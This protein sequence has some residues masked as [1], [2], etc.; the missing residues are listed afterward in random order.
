MRILAIRGRNLASLSG[1]FAIDFTA[2]PLA[3]AG[4][5]AI[6]GPTGAGK[7]TLLDALCLALYDRT[8]RVARVG[9]R[10]TVLPDVAGETIG[11][12]DT[13][14]LLRRGAAEGHAEV[15]FVGGDG[16]AYRA[17]WS[18]RRARGKAGGK[19]Q[20]TQMSLARLPGDEPVGGGLKTEVQAAI[21]ERV[22]LTFEQFTRAVLL[23]QNEFFAFLKAGDDERAALLQAL[24]GTGRF[25]A[26][27]RR[28]F[29]RNKA[30]QEALRQLREQAAQH[31]PLDA[32]TRAQCERQRRQQQDAVKALDERLRQYEAQLR[33]HADAA[34]LARLEQQAIDR[35]RDAVAAHDAA[36]PRR[37]RL[38]D[39]HAAQPARALVAEIDRLAAQ[40]EAQRQELARA[41]EALAAAARAAQDAQAE[42]QRAAAA[43]EA[44]RHAEAAM[45]PRLAQARELDAVIAALSPDR[46]RAA[47]AHRQAG[48]ALEETRRDQARLR[49]ERESAGSALAAAEDWLVRHA[50]LEALG[51]QWPRWDALFAQADD[52][53]GRHAAATQEAARLAALLARAQQDQTDAQG[54][55]ATAAA[56]LQDAQQQY[57][58]A[59]QA[60]A[61]HDRDAIAARA[62]ELQRQRD[63]LQQAAARWR[64]RLAAEARMAELVQQRDTLQAQW[65]Q[66]RQGIDAARAA[67]PAAEQAAAQAERSWQRALAACQQGVE[68]LRETLEPGEP[69]PVCGASEHPY[70][71]DDS[72]LGAALQATLGALEDEYRRCQQALARID[73]DERSAAALARSHGDALA[74]LDT[75]LAAA[76]Q[77]CD[78]AQREWQADAV[79]AQA[80]AVDA[81]ERADWIARQLA[82]ADAQQ[83]SAAEL[84]THLRALDRQVQAARLRLDAGQAEQTA[85]QGALQRAQALAAELALRHGTAN[86]SAAATA[87]QRD[88]ALR[89]LDEGALR[90]AAGAGWRS[91]WHDDPAGLRTRC[92]EDAGQWTRHRGERDAQRQRIVQL[93]GA[94]AA[95]TQAHERALDA[96]RK[97]AEALAFADTR[98]SGRRA[99]REA[100]F[101]GTP[102][103]GL[104]VDAIAA[105]LAQAGADA[106]ARVDEAQ[107]VS[108]A[109]SEQLARQ[110]T[111]AE[112]A[113]SQ[114]EVLD[115][116]A[117]EAAARL[118]A[119]LQGWNDRHDG[120]AA[121]A[122]LD[123]A[124]LRALLALDA[125][126]LA[127][128]EASLHALQREVDAAHGAVQTRR[129]ERER[130]LAR[131]PGQDDAATV[132]AALAAARAEL[133]GAKQA[134]AEADFTLRR[135]DERR[136]QAS[137]LV[138]RIERQQ[139]TAHTWQVLNELIGSADGKKFR[140]HAQQMTLDIL[141]GYAN[142][143]LATLSRRYRL[144]RVRQSLALLVID[145]DMA[146]EAR[147][148]HSLSGGESFL[149]SLALALGL[150]SLSSHRVRVESL[151]IDEG[152]GSL[153]GDTLRVAMD[154]LDSLQ[155]Q[156]RKVGVIS[157]V[158]EMTERIGTRIEVR[159]LSGGQS[160]VTV[161][162]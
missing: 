66:C 124:G 117:R 69:C 56:S 21:V 89:A 39:A 28:A 3:S 150:A 136:A 73:A 36:A 144:E 91:Q 141:L 57:A 132:Q 157:H 121:A 135:D 95:A 64:E 100:L 94:L 33:W 20:Q 38:A 46:E 5:F 114:S 13:R 23:A 10:D 90:H 87:A 30:E 125:D 88:Q 72:P 78:Q 47:L 76:R 26:I 86:E 105:R 27:S 74:Q 147:S 6:C 115:R 48:Q 84:D 151:F 154:A 116:Q 138:T 102:D 111:R 142:R 149:V 131:R 112:Q 65:Q 140:N 106:T 145:Q 93:D 54:R 62:A 41:A 7:S 153:D 53:H 59:Q 75:R 40:R 51:T 137:D 16:Q 129:A 81:G 96:H 109:A 71:H 63:A 97:A 107:R 8:P 108:Q 58:V 61:G 122:P 9:G 103:A 128:E 17:R 37:A 113:Q 12:H 98:L 148:V 160:R 35:H 52:W 133:E 104:T 120:S 49:T 126:W 50:G 1:E 85:A 161:G 80:E 24:T 29:E 139:A 31:Q 118:E 4:L 22:G 127:R 15:D 156:G 159:R 42:R 146:D 25:E 44:A 155:A 67:R 77:Q 152:F 119:W 92:A 123:E 43:L 68:R 79:A 101:A 18:V 82:D 19:L 32:D 110:G 162:A 143:H 55:L 34:D 99:E 134:L 83:R 130:H 14:T 70:A 158:H 2:E 45:A 60:L 11:A